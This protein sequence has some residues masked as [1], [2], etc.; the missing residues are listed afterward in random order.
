MIRWYEY[1]DGKFIDVTKIESID[2]YPNFMSGEEEMFTIVCTMV[3][4]SVIR[5]TEPE[6]KYKTVVQKLTSILS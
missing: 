5:I 3:S 4:G 2:T 6:R 1:V